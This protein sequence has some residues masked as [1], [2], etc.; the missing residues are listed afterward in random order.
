V[1]SGQGLADVQAR[2]ENGA[3]RQAAVQLL[4]PASLLSAGVA[5]QRQGVDG[6]VVRGIPASKYSPR[7]DLHPML[8]V[9][10]SAKDTVLLRT[11]NAS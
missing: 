10:M 9:N 3:N 7:K 11:W 1:N 5:G 6:Q 4:G 2:P 8:R